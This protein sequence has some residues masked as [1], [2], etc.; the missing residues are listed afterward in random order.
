VP[1]VLDAER[2]AAQAA[3]QLASSAAAFKAER[4]TV[5][6]AMAELSQTQRKQQEALDK[7][8]VE[9]RS[10]E[11][12]LKEKVRLD[13]GD[14]GRA[15]EGP[16][17]RFSSGVWGQVQAGARLCILCGL[18]A[19]AGFAR[20][21]LW[22][23]TPEEKLVVGVQSLDSRWHEACTATNRKHRCALTLCGS[24]CRWL[25]L[26]VSRSRLSSRRRRCKSR[27]STGLHWA[28]GGSDEQCLGCA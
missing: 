3:Q 11:G 14:G 26:R 17:F 27:C 8:A 1:Q 7:A 2:S 16:A 9:R 18:G 20:R 15:W 4:D 23:A 22:V 10:L 28:V 12:Q 13:G 6:A 21:H 24:T 19:G 5:E 25:S